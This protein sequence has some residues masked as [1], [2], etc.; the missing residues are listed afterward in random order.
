MMKKITTLLAAGLLG[1]TLA[2]CGGEEAEQ[3]DE[4]QTTDEAIGGVVVINPDG[5][6][7]YIPPAFAEPEAIENYLQSVRPVIADTARDFSR[8]VDPSAGLQD[9]T[10]TLSIEVESIEQADQALEQGLE[11]LQAVEPPEGL[12]LIHQELV[13]AYERAL[14]AFDNIL[15]AFASEDVNQ[16][17]E[18]MREG[19]PEIERF[20]AET[21]AI[22]QELERVETANPDDQAESQG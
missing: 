9:R 12:E 20:N 16:L 18:A 11:A 8:F 10:L 17:A 2:G 22:L 5:A 4:A 21:R 7:F 13:A 3:A 6:E 19:L 14:P 1:L 15:E